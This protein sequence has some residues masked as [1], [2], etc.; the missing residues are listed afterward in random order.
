MHEYTYQAMVYD[1]LPTKNE[2][3][4][5]RYENR[6][7][8]YYD[9]EKNTVILNESEDAIW[10]TNRHLHIG[11]VCTQLPKEMARFKKENRMARMEDERGQAER[12]GQR[13]N[14]STRQLSSECL[15]KSNQYKLQDIANLEQNLVCNFDEEHNQVSMRECIKDLHHKLSIPT[16]GSEERMRLLLL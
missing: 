9:D 2:K 15:E 7:D 11:E 5:L 14:I 10:D 12:E 1:I 13:V 4:Y 3:V 8:R 6:Y 16:T